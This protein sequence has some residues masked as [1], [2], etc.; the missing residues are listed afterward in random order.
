VLYEIEAAVKWEV[1]LKNSAGEPVE[2]AKVKNLAV[3]YVQ[4]VASIQKI[5]SQITVQ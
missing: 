3:E 1:T 2:T 4:L 5:S